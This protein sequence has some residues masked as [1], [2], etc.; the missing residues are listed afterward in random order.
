LVLPEYRGKGLAK[1][2][3]FKAVK[4]IR[5]QHP[6]QSFFCWA[7]SAEGERLATR[8]AEEFHLPLYKRS[9]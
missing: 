8:V 6:I 3:I 4:S 7:F 5:K 2:L 1:N 9:G